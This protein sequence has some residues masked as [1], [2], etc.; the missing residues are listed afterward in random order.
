MTTPTVY[1]RT[2]IDGEATLSGLLDVVAKISQVAPQSAQ[3]VQVAEF[4]SCPEEAHAAEEL[5][6]EPPDHEPVA[7]LA[8]SVEWDPE[9]E[10]S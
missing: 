8:F 1:R 5:G 7:Y 4:Y 6:L 10:E 2:T 3:I 9:E